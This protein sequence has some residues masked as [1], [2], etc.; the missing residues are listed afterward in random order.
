MNA[1]LLLFKYLIQM[2]KNN[3]L[4][5]S[6]WILFSLVNTSV[7]LLDQGRYPSPLKELSDTKFHVPCWFKNAKM[8]ELGI[9]YYPSFQANDAGLIPATLYIYFTV[10][11]VSS[12]TFLYN[13]TEFTINLHPLTTH[14]NSILYSQDFLRINLFF[15]PKES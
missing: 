8:S 10:S 15:L 13:P 4:L 12:I 3:L 6:L 5:F 14:N 1:F 11:P 9:N 2:Y 7:H